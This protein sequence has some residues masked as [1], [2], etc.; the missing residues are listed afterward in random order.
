MIKIHKII[1]FFHSIDITFKSLS[2][3]LLFKY[4]QLKINKRKQFSIGIFIEVDNFRLHS[5]E[6]DKKN[7]IFQYSKYFSKFIKQ[8]KKT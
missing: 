4:I 6:I 7:D 5:N 8:I 1:K 2:N 3:E